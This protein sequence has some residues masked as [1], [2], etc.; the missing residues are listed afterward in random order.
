[1]TED[2]QEAEFLAN[3]AGFKPVDVLAEMFKSMT[4]DNPYRPRR[5]AVQNPATLK[6][7]RKLD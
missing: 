1:M 3:L 6:A 4:V 2:E 5:D 7:V